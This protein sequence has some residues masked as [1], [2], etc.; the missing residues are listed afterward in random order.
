M[1]EEAALADIAGDDGVNFKAVDIEGFDAV[2]TCARAGDGAHLDVCAARAVAVEADAHAGGEVEVDV[3][4]LEVGGSREAEA[5]VDAAGHGEVGNFDVGDVSD[6]DGAA[7]GVD[8]GCDGSA[9]LE[10]LAGLDGDGACAHVSRCED[11]DALATANGVDS[12]LYGSAV[13]ASVDGG[14]AFLRYEGATR[15]LDIIRVEL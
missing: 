13:V 15:A 2:G 12:T 9:A 8:G 10:G 14:A 7:A 4:E 3:A 5:E 6:F 1:Q 11:R